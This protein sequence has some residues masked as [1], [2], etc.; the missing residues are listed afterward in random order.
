MASPPDPYVYSGTRVLRNLL[1]IRDEAA[2]ARTEYEFTWRRRQELE[3]S[4]VQGEF[5]LPHLQEIH[6]RLFCDVF[7]WAGK[8]R[9]VVIS[10]GSSTFLASSDFSPA[11][12]H[13]FGFLRN[14]PLLAG[15][16]DDSTFV[17]EVAEFLSRINFMHPFREGNGR[18]QRAFLDQV[19]ACDGR[20][21]SWRNVSQMDHTRASIESHN[22]GNGKALEP[23]IGRIIEPPLDGLSPFEGAGYSVHGPLRDGDETAF[24]GSRVP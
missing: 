5:G 2:L 1:G 18:A 23:V 13:T 12:E 10:K 11:A 9:T 19:A 20:T 14:G 16:L 3:K 4:P 21:L 17:V 8:L 15:P 7:D 6:R 22:A 24:G